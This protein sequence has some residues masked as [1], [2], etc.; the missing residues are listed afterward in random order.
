MIPARPQLTGNQAVGL[1]V[2]VIIAII[3]IGLPLSF[4]GLA[5][6]IDLTSHPIT[7][8]LMNLLAIGWVVRQAIGRTGG[9]LR[10][11]LPLHRIDASLYLPMLAS[12]LGSAV[13]ISELDNIAVTLY[14]PPEEWAAPLMDIATG[15]HGWLST[16][17]L[18]NVVAPITEECLFRGVILRGFLITYSTRKAVLLSAFLFAAFHM[19]PWQGIGA[20]FLG[21]LFGW[22]YVRTRSLVPC[23]AGHAAFNALPVI[24][25]G[26]LGVEAHDVTQA[27]EFQPLWMNALGVAM[28]GGGVL[29]LQR[30]FQA[31]QPIP[32]TDWLGAVRR[33][34]DRLLKFARDDFGRE[35]TPLFVSQVIAEDNQLPASS[36]SLYVADGRGGAGP[37]SNNLQFD[38]G[39]LRLLYGLSDLTRDEAYAEA[40][41]EYLSYYLERLPLPSG[42]FPWGDHRGYDVVD[43]D[44]IEGHG[45]FTVAL[46]LWHRMWAIDPEAVIRQ[47][48]ALRGH[49]INP[50][51]SLAF[52]RH[53][54]PSGTP[55]C[56]NSSAGAWIVLWTFVHTQTGDQQYLK[57]AKE[58]ADYLWSLRNPDTDLLAAHPHDS[59]YPEMLEN[60]RLSRRAKRTE[61][62]GPMYWY[63][64]NLLRA[65]ELLPSKSEDLF[66]SQALEYIRAFTSRFDATSDGHFYASFDIESGNPLF[67]RIKDGWSLTPQAGPEET[68]SGVVGLRAPIALAYAYRL[69][70]EADLKASFNQLYPL[71]TL[72]RFKDLDGP[73]LPI[74]AGLLAQAIGAWTNLYAATS[75]Y[76]YLAGA[77]TLGRYAAHHYVVNDWFVCGPP[78]VPRYRDDTLSGWETYSNRGGSADLALALLRL[79][80][81]GDGRAELIED[82][83][84]CY[85]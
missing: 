37:T 67:D 2:T 51:R 77:I 18:V 21:I 45:E 76:G 74:S 40:A 72:D 9:G 15:K 46:P 53:H 22:W 42:Y 69:T 56:M 64:V 26:L 60:E 13:I 38:G 49:I 27:P 70:G 71:F 65:Q 19:N 61:Y 20:F 47:A 84:L 68:T 62:L 24:I 6:E 63:A 31:S 34:G 41:D 50:D 57:W 8:G 44:D 5:L 25:I 58:M 39:L 32:V 82:D 59:A 80:G 29:V 23:L 43:D 17:L 3:G 83:P 85:F 78:T 33:F 30:I 7:L 4:V 11:A 14:P 81:I 52:D 75:E 35:V 55:H 73:R 16:I 28:L 79:V 1:L 48:D 12:L 66:R 54:P 10:R 36:T